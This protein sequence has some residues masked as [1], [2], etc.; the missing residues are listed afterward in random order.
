MTDNELITDE[1]ME[2]GLAKF[3][4]EHPDPDE[5]FGYQL[6]FDRIVAEGSRLP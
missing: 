5:S 6:L 3:R 2:A 1:E 4:S